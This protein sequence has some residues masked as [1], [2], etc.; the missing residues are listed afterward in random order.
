VVSIDFN[1]TEV[2]SDR[3]VQEAADSL[4]NSGAT[5]WAVSARDTG[6]SSGNREEV[7]NKMT[8]ASGGR[9]FSTVVSSGLEGLLKT[10]AASLTSQ[11][12]VTFTHPGDSPSRS[13][14][15]ETVRGAKVLLTPFMR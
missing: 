7:L 2:S 14:T 13:T 3:M 4:T 9:R 11:Y 1:S 5:F 15:F 6:P 12:I 8:K 10:V